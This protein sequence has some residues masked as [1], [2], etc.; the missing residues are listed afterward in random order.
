MRELERLT[1]RWIIWILTYFLIH[2]R[3]IGN[4][5]WTVLVYTMVLVVLGVFMATV[6]LN[7]A[8]EL[9]SEYEIRLVEVSL[10]NTIQTK[11][12]LALKYARDLNETGSGYIDI[13]GCPDNITMS[14]ATFRTTA[15]STTL[16]HSS[17][18]PYCEGTHAWNSLEI[19]FNS[20]STDIQ[21]ANFIWAQVNISSAVQ[22][23]TFWD[24]D[25]TFIDLTASFPLTP[26]GIDDNFD[27][28]DYTI[29]SSWSTLYPDVF[30]D[31]DVD[32]RLDTYWYVV[33]NS[34]F[35]NVFWS[36]RLMQDYI[37][38]NTNNNDGYHT[39]LSTTGSGYLYLDIAASHKAKLYKINKQNYTD[40]NELVIEEEIEGED[41]FAN[42]GYLQNNMTLSGSVG[43][44][45]YVFDFTT[46]DYSLFL[47]NTST[48]ALLYQIR[49]FDADTGS[50]IY[51]SPIKDDDNSVFSY[52]GSHMLIDD[53]R[54]IGT[55][56][57]LFEL[58]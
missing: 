14:G 44:N 51:V 6:V 54:L 9:S 31:N 16:R 42:I 3:Y 43:D 48:W 19:Y 56:L 57:E 20:W 8:I 45:A 1:K 41:Q 33:E 10:I 35:Y 2:M 32:A 23:A 4:I 17:S 40:T 11:S 58:K 55:Q 25:D 36:N 13:I 27:S 47:E 28:D 37:D 39:T 26:D 7:V 24:I 46:Y 5:W 18:I 21:Y 22:T 49:A 29:F 30:I 53:G 15:I 12:D 34:G 52:F 50:G 38:S